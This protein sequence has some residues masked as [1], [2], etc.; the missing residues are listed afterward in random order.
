MF[1]FGC[2]CK[3]HMGRSMYIHKFA[4]KSCGQGS[5]HLF[6]MTWIPCPPFARNLRHKRGVLLVHRIF[7]VMCT[8]CTWSKRVM[9]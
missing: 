3:Y 4:L 9:A 1:W 6:V 8:I 7:N 2:K 5:L